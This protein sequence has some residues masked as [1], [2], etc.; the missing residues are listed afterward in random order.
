LNGLNNPLSGKPI[1]MRHANCFW[2][3]K[4]DAG[5]EATTFVNLLMN[6]PPTNDKTKRFYVL[7]KKV[8]D[9][10]RD[11]AGCVAESGYGRVLPSEL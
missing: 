6:N 1:A 9:D 2:A 7:V 4:E 5:E 8:S 3:H 10:T 11:S